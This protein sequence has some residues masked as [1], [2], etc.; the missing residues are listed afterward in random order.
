VVTREVRK[1][2][3]S[4]E[5]RALLS[6]ELGAN[7]HAVLSLPAGNSPSVDGVSVWQR[8]DLPPPAKH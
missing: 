6:S 8:N 7:Y 1:G 2:R 4:P 3:R 5:V